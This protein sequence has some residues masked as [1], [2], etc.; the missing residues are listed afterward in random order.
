M[1]V[2]GVKNMADVLRVGVLCMGPLEDEIED[3]VFLRVPL[4]VRHDDVEGLPKTASSTRPGV[5]RTQS[6]HDWLK[7]TEYA[8]SEELAAKRVTSGDSCKNSSE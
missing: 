1:K 7:I 5:G 4:L 6:K 8:C 3:G 2:Y